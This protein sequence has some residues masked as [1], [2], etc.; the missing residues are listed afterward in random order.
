[1]NDC[2]VAIVGGGMVG[3]TL[4]LMLARHTNLR[5]VVLE[6]VAPGSVEQGFQPSFDGRSTALSRTTARAFEDLLLWPQIAAYSAPIRHILVSERGRLGRFRLHAEEE[7]VEAFG[8][9]MEN[10]GLGHVLHKVVAATPSITLKAPVTVTHTQT[11]ATRTDLFL[12]DGKQLRTRL[13]VAADGAESRL[14]EAM[15]IG[16]DRYDYGQT[17]LVC[18]VQVSQPQH[19]T[20]WERFAGEEILAMLPRVDGSKALIWTAKHDRAK[21]LLRMH[22]SIFLKQLT[23]LMGPAQ[24]RF[25]SRTLPAAY[26]LQRIMAQH[27]VLPGRV[28]LGNAAHFL[29]PVAGQGFN[30]CVRDAQVLTD[31]L[32]PHVQAGGDPGEFSVLRDY[33]QRR[34]R[35]QAI[36]TGFSEGLVRFFGW[37]GRGLSHIRAMGLML[38]DLMPGSKTLLARLTMGAV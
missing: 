24:G 10:S 23:E 34:R 29:H 26:P 16:T 6:S 8:F 9:V 31:V 22:E 15:L 30:L 32:A 18:N 1:M 27:Q 38:A 5:I 2:D 7:G 20:A 37:E 21:A 36:I 25:L 33:E 3:M 19:D 11:V 35:D 28:I 4:A 14:R 12:S 17:A 13:L